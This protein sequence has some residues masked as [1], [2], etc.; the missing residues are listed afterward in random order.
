MKEMRQLR[1]QLT[2]LINSINPNANLVVDPKMKPPTKIQVN[3]VLSIICFINN[4]I[5]KQK[6]EKLLRQIIL[7]GFIDQIG[8]LKKNS[9]LPN[10]YATSNI[11]SKEENIFVHPT[12][13]LYRQCPDWVVYQELFKGSKLFL[14]GLIFIFVFCF[15]IHILTLS[16]F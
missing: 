7:S 14:K 13:S 15:L 8:Y 2:N 12:S 11:D 1:V 6:K 10:A 4:L 3:F 9:H 5:F 16:F